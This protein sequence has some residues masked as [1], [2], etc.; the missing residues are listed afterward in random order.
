VTGKTSTGLYVVAGLEII[1]AVV[2][3]LFIPARRSVATTES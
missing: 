1:A 3:L 2:I